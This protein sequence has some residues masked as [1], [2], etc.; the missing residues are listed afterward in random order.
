MFLNRYFENLETFLEI[1]F[2][3]DFVLLGEKNKFHF[4]IG[5]QSRPMWPRTPKLEI[6]D[7][8]QETPSLALELTLQIYQR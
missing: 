5:N 2:Q 7:M 1:E 3:S 4:Q 8:R 6:E